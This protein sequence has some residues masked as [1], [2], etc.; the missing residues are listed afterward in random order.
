[1]GRRP[2]VSRQEVLAAARAAFAERGYEGTTLA[3]IAS[4]LSV[5]PAALLRHEPNKAA[6]FQ[7]ALAATESTEP[8]PMAFLAKLTGEEDPRIVLRRLAEEF[9]P[10]AEAKI[11]E[12]VARW[13]RTAAAPSEIGL[14][15]T[16]PQADGPRRGLAFV[17]AYFRRAQSAGRIDVEDPR[18][19]ALAFMASLQSYVFLHRVAR[20]F[21]TPLPLPRYLDSLLD[22]W[23]RGALRPAARIVS[24]RKKR[25]K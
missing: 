17:E 6:L 11:G 3:A 18:A 15:L 13:Q 22:I 23:T 8:L 2:L 25:P 21:P 12:S 19:A 14:T 1:M 20:V 9:V 4:R 5:S 24:P 16:A 7:A 10:F